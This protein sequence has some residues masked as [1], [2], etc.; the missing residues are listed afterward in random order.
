MSS[1]KPALARSMWRRLPAPVKKVVRALPG[2][3]NVAYELENVGLFTSLFRHELML[4]DRVRVDTY[5]RGIA[6]HVKPGDVV[7]DL[8][9]G[10]GVLA[11]LAIGAGARKV[12]AVDHSP[13]IE[14]ARAIAARNGTQ[15]IEF[16]QQSSRDFVPP[17]PIDVIV[18]EQMGDELLNENMLV[19]IS[20]LKRRVL[21]PGGRVIPALFDLFLE[22]V[23]LLENVHIPRLEAIEI[24]GFDLS[25][26]ADLALLQPYRDDV[27]YGTMLVQPGRPFVSALLANPQPALSFNLNEIESEADAQASSHSRKTVVR[28]GYLDGFSCYFRCRFDAE[29]G[30]DTSPLSPPTHWANRFYRTERRA[31]SKGEVIDCSVRLPDFTDARGW[32]VDIDNR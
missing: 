26:T 17:E 6:R 27:G 5:R 25:V 31:V 1:S 2:A 28:S 10:T 8:G 20:D 22:P 32:R 15:G 4:S 7:L 11:A 18:H 30:F 23:E 24:E 9:T 19:S 3:R 13:F 12:Y 16:V 29:I 14:V 21:R